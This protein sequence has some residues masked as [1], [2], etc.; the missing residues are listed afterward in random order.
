[1]TLES[2]MSVH[3]FVCLSVR[4]FSSLTLETSVLFTSEPDITIASP[5][6]P[7]KTFSDVSN[8]AMEGEIMMTRQIKFMENSLATQHFQPATENKLYT[9]P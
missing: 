6:A 3:I 2:L 4:L 1:M 7:L 8:L 9:V 5:S